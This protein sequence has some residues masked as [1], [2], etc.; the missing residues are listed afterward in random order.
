MKAALCE[1]VVTGS[2]GGDRFF[3]HST[4]V[5]ESLNISEFRNAETARDVSTSLDMT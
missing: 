3:C 2:I 5:E 4:E 1:R